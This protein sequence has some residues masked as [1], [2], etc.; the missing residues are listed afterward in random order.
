MSKMSNL[1]AVLDEVKQ[2]ICDHYC[3]FPFEVE[4]QEQMD[5]LCERCPLSR[6]DAV[7]SHPDNDGGYWYYHPRTG[8][9]VIVRD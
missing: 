3:R 2:N 1:A 7:Q 8:E 6:I 9:M 5:E 4:D